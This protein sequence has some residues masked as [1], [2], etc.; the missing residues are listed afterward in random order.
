M[1]DT[2]KD[3]ETCCECFR[4]HWCG[5]EIC[6][7]EQFWIYGLE[8]LVLIFSV[9]AMVAVIDSS[10]YTV[11]V[12]SSNLPSEIESSEDL[13]GVD[14]SDLFLL[15]GNVL[16]ARYN[17]AL[18]PL[19]GDGL[20]TTCTPTEDIAKVF[21]LE[22]RIGGAGGLIIALMTFNI[23]FLSLLMF[24]QLRRGFTDLETLPSYRFRALLLTQFI[25]LLGTIL[26]ASLIWIGLETTCENLPVNGCFIQCCECLEFYCLNGGVDGF[27]CSE[28]A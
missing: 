23:L 24:L 5:F 25:V 18:Q 20:E 14:E 4:R 13:A 7:F 17:Q 22:D 2:F 12:S 9:I 26:A 8:I 28:G 1:A 10:T 6:L 16:F 11:E 27:F 19:V 3:E 21:S 15:H